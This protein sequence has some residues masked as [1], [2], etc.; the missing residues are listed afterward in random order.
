MI[1]IEQPNARDQGRTERSYY[2]GLL[3]GSGPRSVGVEDEQNVKYFVPDV[4]A[5]LYRDRYGPAIQWGAKWSTNRWRMRDQY[6]S[7]RK[8]PG[9]YRIAISGA[10][11]VMGRCVADG[12]NFES[13]AE[14]HFNASGAKVEIL[15]FAMSA[16]CSLQR[17]AD[18]ELRI[19]EF[20]PDLFL[21]VC[22]AGEV[23]RKQDRLAFHEG[24]TT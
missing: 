8:S 21:I 6:Y 15:N 11:Y 14:D 20:Q 4:R 12:E 24:A 7:K 9:A 16:N 1:R 2:E 13:V 3:A 5:V 17:V 23:E 18:L 10:S 22:H 19:T